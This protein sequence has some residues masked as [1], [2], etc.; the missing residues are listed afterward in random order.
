MQI[1]KRASL[2][3]AFSAGLGFAYRDVEIVVLAGFLFG[4]FLKKFRNRT[5][6]PLH[7]LLIF[8]A[9][10]DAALLKVFS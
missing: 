4:K 5:Y 8:V 1:V 9:R 3:I 7:G 2:G 6:R 10:G